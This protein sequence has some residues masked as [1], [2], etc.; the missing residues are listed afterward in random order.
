MGGFL[1][2]VRDITADAVVGHAPFHLDAGVGDVG[3]LQ[4]V[5]GL[6]EDGFRQVFADFVFVNV[7]GG[8]HLDVLDAVLANPVVHHPGNWLVLRHLHV[9]VEALNQR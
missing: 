9:L 4:S 8:D 6:S 5:V 7:E 3:E 2:Q 1:D